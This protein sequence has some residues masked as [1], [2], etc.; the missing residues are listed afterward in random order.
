MELK[1]LGAS[2][3]VTGSC[4]L[5]TVGGKHFLIDCGMEQGPDIYEN[6]PLPINPSDIDSVFLTHAHIDHSGKLPLLV[7]GGF[8]GKIYTTAA[9]AKLCSIMLL[10]SAHIQEY[11]AEWRNRRAKRSGEE[12]YTPL[13]TVKDAQKTIQLFESCDYGKSYEI[14]S[15]VSVSFID[16]GHLLGSASVEVNASENGETRK[17][18]FSGDIGNSNRPLIKNPQK[19]KEA[20]YVVIESTY[21]DRIHRESGMTAEKIAPIIQKALDRGGNLVIPS[22]AVGRTQEMLYIIRKIKEQGLVKNHGNFPVFIDSPLAIEATNIYSSDL[23][24]YYDEEAKTL[25][26]AGIN[27]IAFPG[28][29][30]AVS[31]D[32]SKKINLDQRPKV[33]ISASGMCEAGRIKH[34]LKHNL[35]RSDSTVLFIGYQSV[36][37]LGRQITDGADGVMIFGEYVK[38]NANIVILEGSSSHADRDMMIDWLGGIEKTPKTVFVN[39]GEDRVA[40]DFAERLCTLGYRAEAPY[41]GSEYDLI[42]GMCRYEG[43]REKLESPA[44]ARRK[45]NSNAAFERLRI[46]GQRLIG[47][48]EKHRR[49]S[50]KDI[51]KLTSQINSLCDK[52]EKKK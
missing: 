51:A 40:E 11:E 26:D 34:H 41:N 50:S 39:H 33:I 23:E 8:K 46:A 38:I 45:Q 42:S 20:D 24:D 4:T 7:A 18:L 14:S 31:S 28:L 5:L 9:T 36:G 30:V 25:I 21:G 27:P 17:I 48:I 37:T 12:G 16:A 2:R 22:F 32:D 47:V 49:A 15:S 19:P 52:Y 43:S 10:D 35:W 13:Y 3:E 29:Q 1:F 6:E 44:D